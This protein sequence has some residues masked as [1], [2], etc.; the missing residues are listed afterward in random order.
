LAL[1]IIFG[2]LSGFS[3]SL[4]PNLLSKTEKQIESGEANQTAPVAVNTA[5]LG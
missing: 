5:N 1:V 4:V 3:E 2:V